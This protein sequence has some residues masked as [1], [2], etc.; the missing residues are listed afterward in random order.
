MLYVYKFART[1]MDDNT[2]VIPYNQ[3]GS[4]TGHNNG[5]TV[6]MGF[7]IYV[8]RQTSV[9]PWPGDVGDGSYFSI[10]GPPDSEVFFDQAILST[11]HQ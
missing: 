1:A 5:D 10:T 11:N 7:R 2:F 3:D 6:F 8:D 4:F 9:G